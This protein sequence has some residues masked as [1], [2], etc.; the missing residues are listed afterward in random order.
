MAILNQSKEFDDI[1]KYELIVYPDTKRLK[2]IQGTVLITDFV[3]YEDE[4]EDGSVNPILSIQDSYGD[5]YKGQ[6]PTFKRSFFQIIDLLKDYPI[7]IKII[8]GKSK[9]EREYIDCILDT[10]KLRELRE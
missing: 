7:P 9:S 10:K 1:Q 3:E 5:V 8:I 2:D 6:S 4:K